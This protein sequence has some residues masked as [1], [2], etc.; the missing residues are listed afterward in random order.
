MRGVR[1]IIGALVLLL[2]LAV[3]AVEVL[4][5][6]VIEQRVEARVRTSTASVV[7]VEAQLNSFPVLTR[8][9]ATERVESLDVRLEEV[10]TRQ[11]PIAELTF[12]LRGVII[13]RDELLRGRLR[14][15][16]IERA[17]LRAEL[18]E[19]AVGELLGVELD[20][21][22]LAGRVG[23]P[24]GVALPSELMPC[25]PQ[26]AVEESVVV[27]TCSVDDLPGVLVRALGRAS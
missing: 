15:R 3:V 14:I 16:D 13:D 21:S 25:A 6:P 8:A 1:R 20:V 22:D 12:G 18:R 26:I 11:I 23:L 5:P 7:G 17:V 2:V 4:A 19:Q 10:A 9:L 24:A 27:L